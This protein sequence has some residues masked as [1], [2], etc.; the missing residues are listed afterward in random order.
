M[1][2]VEAEVALATVE[3]EAAQAEEATVE[4]SILASKIAA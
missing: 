1:A 4:V 2:T 3:A